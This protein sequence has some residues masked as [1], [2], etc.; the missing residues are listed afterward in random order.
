MLRGLGTR[1]W[2]TLLTMLGVVLGVA[3]VLAVQVT[4]QSTMASIESIFDRATGKAELLVVPP[5]EETHLEGDLLGR[6]QRTAGVLVAAPGVWV[7]TSLVSDIQDTT[8]LWG[9]E[10]LQVGRP[11][12]LHGIDLEL[13]PLV[14]VYTLE[15]GRMPLPGRYETLLPQKY[16]QEKALKLGDWLEIV[17]LKGTEKLRIVGLLGEEGAAMSNSGAVAFAPL[18]VVQDMFNLGDAFNEIAVQVAPGI[19]SSVE[20]LAAVKT[21]LSDRLGRSG[22]VIYPAARS[23][24]VPRMLSSYQLGLLFFSI[25]AVFTGAFL[26]YNTFSMTVVERTQEIGMLRAIGMSRGQILSMV[27]IEAAFMALIGSS[28]GVVAGLFLARSLSAL[29]GGFMTVEKTLIAA[30]SADLAFSMGIGIAVT[31]L[32]AL[33]PAN[34]AASIPPLEA[35]RVKAHT[36]QAV[37]PV[38]WMLG[39]ALIPVGWAGI[40]RAAWPQISRLQM[41]VASFFVFLLG[42]VLTVPLAVRILERIARVFVRAIYRNEGA[43]GSAN[44]CRSVQRTSMTVASLMI[45]LIMIIGVGSISQVITQDV[46]SWLNNAMGGDLIITAEEP[47]RTTFIEKLVSLP[48]VSVVNPLRI[49]EVRVGKERYG[50]NRLDRPRRER[51]YLFAIDPRL[52]RRIGDKEFISG[53]GDPRANWANL[54]QGGALFISSIVAE[55]YGVGQGDTLS[56]I[57]HRGEH[58]FRIAGVTTEFTRQGYIITSTFDDLERWFGE[59]GA[60]QFVLKMAP[61]QEVEQIAEEIKN[62]YQERYNLSVQTTETYRKSMLG[63]FGQATQLFEALSLVGVVIGAMGVLN[64][65]T[66]NVL[67]RQREVGSLRSQGM[68]RGQVVRMV[69]AEALVM[70]IIG[71]VYGLLFGNVISHIFLYAINSISS[72]ELNYLFTA[73]PY[74]ISLF[75]ALVVSELAAISP[76]QRAAKVNIISALK[77]E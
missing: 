18:E 64:T 47:L 72:Y 1:P 22:Q 68:L 19:G 59:S 76:A 32:A 45:S 24:L 14:H 62:R 71:A 31:L 73:R 66:M 61:G 54:E 39:L 3:V 44:V 49:M 65:M 36:G 42:V 26:I 38:V 52:Y 29:M 27:L 67:E 9:S 21:D 69:L 48:G 63:L 43:L 5:G 23:D 25:I 37:S 8:T 16:A 35:L 13:D 46:Q 74:W 20:A 4:N 15:N 70:G 34:R 33:L 50:T 60:N 58:N 55:E 40:Y 6:V 30:S 2:R 53:Q 28:L 7:T 77:H 51:L 57:T 75:V 41:G 17:T 12:E 10:G 56:L 11:F